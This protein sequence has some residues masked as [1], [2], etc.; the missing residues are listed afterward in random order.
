MAD[1]EYV[2][3]ICQ[4][5]KNGKV[6]TVEDNR[7]RLE[8]ELLNNQSETSDTLNIGKYFFKK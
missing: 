1:N 8:D 5:M 3:V 4:N 7:D 2:Y 6:V